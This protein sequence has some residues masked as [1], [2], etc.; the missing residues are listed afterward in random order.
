MTFTLAL[1]FLEAQEEG[2]SV[3]YIIVIIRNRKHSRLTGK[4]KLFQTSNCKIN[5]SMR[6]YIQGP[7]NYIKKS[8]RNG[9]LLMITVR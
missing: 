2:N 5:V 9:N 3:S 4:I 7:L 6:L 8:L 1:G